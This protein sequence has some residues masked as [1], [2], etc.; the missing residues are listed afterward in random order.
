[1]KR[2]LPN[3]REAGAIAILI[4]LV[5]VLFGGLL[6]AKEMADATQIEL[7]AKTTEAEALRRRL[8]LPRT[9]AGHRADRKRVPDRSELR[10]RRKFAAAISRR[11]DRDEWRQAGVGR[12][13]AA[14]DR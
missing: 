7:D 13:R 8:Q 10:A 11:D 5:I 12:C 3:S 6:F 4:G 14:A 1:M 2:F 9:R